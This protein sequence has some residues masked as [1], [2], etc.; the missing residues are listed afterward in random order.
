MC[1]CEYIFYR[2]PIHLAD[3]NKIWHR[4]SPLG[5]EGSWPV[6]HTVPLLIYAIYRLVHFLIELLG[7]L[8][9]HFSLIWYVRG[10]MPMGL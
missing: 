5:E 6:F 1:V 3:F 10:S 8:Y 7:P 4:G 2:N 9:L